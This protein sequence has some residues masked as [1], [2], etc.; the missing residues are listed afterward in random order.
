MTTSNSY[1]ISSQLLRYDIT[2]PLFDGR[3][4]IEGIEFK[5]FKSSP[6]VFTDIPQIREGN[7]DF[8]ELNMGYFNSAFELGWE[9]IGLPI[10]PK[11]KPVYQFIFCRTD[12]GIKSPKELEGKK[13]GTGQYRFVVVIWIA[14]FLKERHGVNTSKM[15][16]VSQR[17]DIFPYL[18]PDMKIEYVE[19]E[20]SMVDRLIDCEVDAIITDISDAKL[21]KTL[22]TSPLVRR[23]FPNYI[24]EDEKLYKEMG[25]YAPMH[26]IVMSKKLNQQKPDLAQK[27]C[28][29]FDEAKRITYDDILS[30]MAGFTVVNLRERMKEQLEHW[31]DLWKHGFKA[32]RV[33]METFN[34]YNFE[35]GLTRSNLPVKEMFA[36]N[37]LDT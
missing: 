20:K 18:N 36:K 3:V 14:G 26:L 1:Q 7:F 8:W 12:S 35:Q 30:D 22:E 23:L 19:G 10:F 28:R 37:T 34:R 16:W 33:T 9:L 25:I 15:R 2:M 27:L 4:A 17:R 29:A 11:R 5:P 31:G 24:E 21:F 32:N 13:I 6:M